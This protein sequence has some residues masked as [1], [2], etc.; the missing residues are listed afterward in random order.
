M[1]GGYRLHK[2]AYDP[3]PRRQTATVPSPA[4]TSGQTHEG[5]NAALMR[6]SPANYGLG[7]ADEYRQSVLRYHQQQY[8][9]SLCFADG[10]DKFTQSVFAWHRQIQQQHGSAAWA[11][12]LSVASRFAT[13]RR[14]MNAATANS[15]HQWTCGLARCNRLQSKNIKTLQHCSGPYFSA[16]LV[17]TASPSWQSVGPMW[18]SSNCLP[19]GVSVQDGVNR[20]TDRDSNKFN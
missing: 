6:R 17:V 2:P 11:D 16:V 12:K 10:R 14:L 15:Q 7:L 19:M 18:C 4:T 13:G 8:T 5:E 1:L 20:R 9:M 3:Y